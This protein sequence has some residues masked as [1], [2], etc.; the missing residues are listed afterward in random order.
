MRTVTIKS[1][2]MGRFDDD[3]PFLIDSGELELK[4]ILPP[5]TA[6]EYYLVW[7]M[8]GEP[9]GKPVQLPKS[10]E[11][12]IPCASVGRLEMCVKYYIRGAF[13]TE[14]PVE[15][16]IIRAVHNSVT[17]TPELVELR[18]R[19]ADLETERESREK[20]YGELVETVSV[21]LHARDVSFLAFAWADYLYNVQMN[22]KGLTLEEFLGA[23]GYSAGDF[24]AG[25][26]KEIQTMK[27]K[28]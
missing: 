13:V 22:A 11:V 4:F 17:A 20:A 26:I 6:G 19:I 27:E 1:G 9:K 21:A 28:F 2:Q 23:L 14:Y 24:T 7:E 10:G 3:S 15:P 12:A 5:Q 18:N 25:E 8:D 16:L